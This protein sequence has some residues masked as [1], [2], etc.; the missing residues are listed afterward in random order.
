[1]GVSAG[2]TDFVKIGLSVGIPADCIGVVERDAKAIRDK[3][4]LF[5]QSAVALASNPCTIAPTGFGVS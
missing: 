2:V 3:F 1:M 4:Q 5:S